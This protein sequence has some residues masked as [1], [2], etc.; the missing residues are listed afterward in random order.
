M[1]KL[2]SILLS[3]VIVLSLASPAFAAEKCNCETL[4]VVYVPG[5]GAGI[6]LNPDSDDYVTLFPPQQEAIDEALPDIIKAV[7]Y[8]LI[9][10]QYDKFGTLAIKAATPLLGGIACNPD[11]TS[12]ENIGVR[13][14]DPTY[15]DT[16]QNTKYEFSTVDDVENPGEYYFGY[17]WR[18]DPIENAK[19]L[20]IFIDKVKVVTGHNEI[21]LSSHSQGNTV[22]TSY[23]HLYS[24][25]GIAK[26]VLLSPAYQGLSLVGALLTR[27]A[28]VENKGDEVVEFIKGIMDYSDPTN[29]LI[30]ALV[31]SLNKVGILNCLLGRLQDIL[32]SQLDRVFD[33]FLIDCMGT[34]PGVWSFVPAHQYEEA[35]IKTFRGLD[36]YAELEKKTDYYH[37]NVKI[38]TTEILN[39]A[40]NNGTAI[41]ISA[42][43]DISNI[44]VT[45]ESATHSD[46]LIDTKNMSIGA[47][48]S[49]IG[50]TLGADYK[51]AKTDCGHNHISADN[52]IDAST[53]CFPEQ[54]WF[55]KGNPHNE[56]NEAYRDFITWAIL[57]K[58]QPDVHSSEKYPQFI[59]V[60]GNELKIVD[61]PDQ[62]E[63][64]SN[65]RIIFE[66]LFY[67]IKD[68]ISNK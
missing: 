32:D 44:P 68:S 67:L 25:E 18:L 56:F 59:S 46:F 50:G 12:P 58:G 60:K 66:S 14:S 5:F 47:T 54:T 24:N 30:I 39:E 27:K 22:V 62:A 20:K 35:K 26:L 29:Q 28:T 7:I 63:T 19:K 65:F 4:P 10:K 15:Y 45:Y 8:G 33:E 21:V 43:Y 9:L 49:P 6:H 17:D 36:K 16:H 61:S 13:L 55:I 48:C 41:V 2:T 64:R 51:Q 31:S 38:K 11:G 52:K 57:F 37:Y 1:K 3:F 34:M 40:K 23:L 53:S 42:G